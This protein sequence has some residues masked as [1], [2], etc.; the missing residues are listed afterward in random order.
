MSALAIAI[1]GLGL[2]GHWCPSYHCF[3]PFSM[4]LY[5]ISELSLQKQVWNSE[6]HCFLST[7]RLCDAVSGDARLFKVFEATKSFTLYI[8]FF[9]LWILDDFRRH[10]WKKK[11][12]FV[13]IFSNFCL[14]IKV[15]T[16]SSPQNSP[17]CQTLTVQNQNSDNFGASKF[18]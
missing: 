15:L 5:S 11:A 6:C 17:K 3:W 1:F 8:K 2:L 16:I 10:P 9:L 4:A 13:R 18:T 14:K 12:I 7:S